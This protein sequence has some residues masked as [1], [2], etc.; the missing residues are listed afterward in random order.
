MLDNCISNEAISLL[1]ISADDHAFSSSRG[2][3]ADNESVLE[4]V[5][6]G[7]TVGA[8]LDSKAAV[9]ADADEVAVC[10]SD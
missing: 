3:C 7:V 2:G 10:T 4:P 6:E 9:V 1:K 8:K 5:S